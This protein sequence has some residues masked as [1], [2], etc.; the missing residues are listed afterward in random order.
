M[1]HIFDTAAVL[2]LVLA[3][4]AAAQSVTGSSVSR[5]STAES[6]SAVEE[7]WSPSGGAKRA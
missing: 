5:F 2:A 4:P 3:A 6:T 1:R 7:V